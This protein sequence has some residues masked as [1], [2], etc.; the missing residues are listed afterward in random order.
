MKIILIGVGAV[1]S[2]LIELLNGFQFARDFIKN[3]D[4]LIIFDAKNKEN[5]PTIKDISDLIEVELNQLEIKPENIEILLNKIVPGDLVID[6][7]YN[8]YYKSVIEHCLKVNANYINTSVERWQLENESNVTSN[9]LKR[10][11]HETHKELLKLEPE[12]KDTDDDTNNDS[13]IIV[14]H[15]MNPG[16]ISHFVF[17]GLKT[18]TEEILQQLHYNP[19]G[20]NL[21][22]IKL[23][24]NLLKNKNYPKLAEILGL[25]TIQCSELDTQETD[26]KRNPNEFLNTWGSYSFYSEGVDP[27][28]IG[29]GT[30]EKP[31]PLCIPS[32]NENNQIYLSIRGIELKTNSYVPIVDEK[33]QVKSQ[34]INGM[35]ISH[36]END[37]LSKFFTIKNSVGRVE[38]RP[39]VYYVYSPCKESLESFEEIK[40]NNY[41]ML[42]ES[43][44]LRGNEIKSGSDSVGALLIFDKNPMN[45]FITD[46]SRDTKTLYWCGSILDINQTRKLGF[47][48]SGPTTVQV[49]ISIFSVISQL[50][51]LKGDKGDKDYKSLRGNKRILFPEE[52]EF[53]K[54][55]TPCIPFLGTFFSDWIPGELSTQFLGT[56]LHC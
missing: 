53:E 48:Y 14:T 11:L 37:T 15:G 25:K 30:H 1:G 47:R 29:F 17:H 2:T 3:Y 56:Q 45:K 5:E 46:M 19:I 40:N 4:K 39:S 24:S 18:I 6:L 10:T 51:S 8:I 7:S 34:K 52:L 16:L 35:L 23:L 41:E 27:V 33:S 32:E 28:Q 9:F 49:A 21:V 55:L 44:V 50:K 31:L 54:I 12:H 36:S 20:D 13:L 43:R 42:K 38:Y 26:V 22:H